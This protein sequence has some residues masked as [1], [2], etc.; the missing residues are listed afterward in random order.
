MSHVISDSGLGTHSGFKSSFLGPPAFSFLL[1][2][3]KKA[4]EP[5]TTVVSS[6]LQRRVAM[7][8][9]GLSGSGEQRFFL[10]GSFFPVGSSSVRAMGLKCR[11]IGYIYNQ[12]TTTAFQVPMPWHI[13]GSRL[14]SSVNLGKSGHF[15][16]HLSSYQAPLR[17]TFPSPGPW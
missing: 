11:L 7:G 16:M 15:K 14:S 8:L 12:H 9:R 1:F 6:S 3:S 13:V 10:V 17:T 2:R 4:T 5:A